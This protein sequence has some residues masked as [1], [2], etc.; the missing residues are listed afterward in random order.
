MMAV[1]L[2]ASV[3]TGP[4]DAYA[5]AFHR[6]VSTGRPLVVLL[7]ADWCPGCVKMKETI[8]PQVADYGA[9]DRVE[10]AYV[11]VD[12]APQLAGRLARAGAIPQ[13]I[14]FERTSTGWTKDVL[15]GAHSPKKVASFINPEPNGPS[16]PSRFT[17]TLGSWA[18][19]ITG[20]E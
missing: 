15:T 20:P 18:K 14:R 2:Q 13:L 12:Q 10:F 1:M 7:G 5:A 16:L 9:L 8:L 4:E 19:R 6:S 17:D 3:A 11:D